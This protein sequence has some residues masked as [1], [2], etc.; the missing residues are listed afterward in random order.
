MKIFCYPQSH[1]ARTLTLGHH[2]DEISDKIT[3]TKLL[4]PGQF[5]AVSSLC[6]VH[7]IHGVSCILTQPDNFWLLNSAFPDC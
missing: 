2:F 5:V 6:L 4:V 3:V 1:F 7:Y